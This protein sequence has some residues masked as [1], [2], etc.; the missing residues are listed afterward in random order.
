MDKDVKE[1]ERIVNISDLERMIQKARLDVIAL[2]KY[3]EKKGQTEIAERLN[4]IADTLWK[5]EN[6]EFL[7][8]R[9]K[10]KE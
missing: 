9:R 3:T 7:L 6:F 2:K 1:T 8:E 10:I 4:E 5:C